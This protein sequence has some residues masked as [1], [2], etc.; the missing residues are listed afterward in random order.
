MEQARLHGLVDR[1]A[2][3]G[4]RAA[5]AVF[6]QA[7]AAA[8][9]RRAARTG[10][11]VVSGFYVPWD[12]ASRAS[13]AAHVDELDWVIPAAAFVTGPRASL[14]RR[15]PTRNSTRSSPARS[16]RPLVLPMV[17]NAPERPAG[18]APASPPC[19]TIP[20][21]AR[22]CSTGSRRWSRR[23]TAP[24]SSS[25]SR[26]SRPPRQ[27]DYL[28]FLGR[29]Q[30][31]LRRRAAG[32]SRWRRR[33]AI[34]TGTSPPTPMSTDKIFL[35]LYD[36]HWAGRRPRPDRLAGLVRPPPAGGGARRSAPTR[37][38]RPSPITA[39]TGRPAARRG[40]DRRGGLADGARQ[41][42]DAALRSG[43]RQRH[44]RL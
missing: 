39:M 25:T 37:R 3:A 35:M 14:R 9:R 17:Q 6:G 21:P 36:E 1:I 43:Q 31:P 33:S 38:S 44:L 42:G 8:A 11:Q 18:T 34:P 30:S 26:R 22:A 4:G 20:R 40:A 32:R 41:R 5:R 29:G 28:R 12:E 19:C 16:G 10:R 7:L 13:L 2:G 23:G 24:A 15:S 27:R